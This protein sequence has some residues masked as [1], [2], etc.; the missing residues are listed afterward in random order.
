MTLIAHISDLHIR[1]RGQLA[2]GVSETNGMAERAIHALLRLDPA[3]D[4]LLIT[5][6]LT[7][8]GLDEEFALLTALLD[9]LPFPV[10]AIPGNHDRREP[11]RRAFSAAGYLPATGPLDF[12]VEVGGIRI[13]GLDTLVPGKSHGELAET[14][15]A[16]LNEA[17]SEASS[18]PTMIMI[19]HPPFDTGIAHMDAIRLLAGGEELER[20]IAAHR[21]VQR[22][23]CGHVHRAIQTLF[24]RTIAQIAPSVGHQV[25]FDLN[26]DGPSSF[27]LEPPAFLIHRLEGA[28]ITSHHVM[29]DRAPG[30][31]PFILPDDYP[32]Q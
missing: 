13:I 9:R 19:H 12:T 32:G 11:F 8:C 26:H 24:G 18:M 21:Q 22:L 4:C 14:S 6:D 1:P 7:D 28:S 2:Y 31:F 27:V 10:F 16:F 25:T 17:L 29:V 23:L 20:I 5:G 15:L 3:P 30:P